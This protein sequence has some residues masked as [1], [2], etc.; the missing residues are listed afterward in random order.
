MFSLTGNSIKN[1]P[2]GNNWEENRYYSKGKESFN[3]LFE[4]KNYALIKKTF[5][6]LCEFIVIIKKMNDIYK[7]TL[8]KEDI[9]NISHLKDEQLQ[10]IKDKI[11]D[12]DDTL[13]KAFIKCVQFQS[14]HFGKKSKNR[15]HLW[16]TL[17]LCLFEVGLKDFYIFI[18][19]QEVFFKSD[20]KNIIKNIE[21]IN[22]FRRIIRDFIYQISYSFD[23]KITFIS[24]L[25]NQ[26]K[27]QKKNKRAFREIYCLCKHAQEIDREMTLL[28]QEEVFN[29]GLH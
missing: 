12:L 24:D 15:H 20:L 26:V 23:F 4:E 1:N 29:D 13:Q 28:L 14:I 9:S 5:K 25:I 8:S 10:Q 18:E 7:N 3:D 2:E 17:N 21:D 11:I 16:L 6:K 22:I 27:I 19:Y